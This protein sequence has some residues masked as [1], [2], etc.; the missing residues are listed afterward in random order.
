MTNLNISCTPI[1]LTE[2]IKN[3]ILLTKGSIFLDSSYLNHSDSHYSIIAFDP[4][5]TISI[6]IYEK[7]N[8]INLKMILKYY[9]YKEI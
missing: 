7:T 8:L 1:N 9:P 2:P 6:H 3:S 4:Y 5:S